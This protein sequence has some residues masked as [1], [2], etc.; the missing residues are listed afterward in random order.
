LLNGN[1]T[2][3]SVIYLQGKNQTNPSVGKI[4]LLKS[5]PVSDL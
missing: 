3:M 1:D 2:F 4:I 5:S